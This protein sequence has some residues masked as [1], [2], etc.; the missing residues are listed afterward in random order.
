M[1]QVTAVDFLANALDINTKSLIFEQAKEME[2]KLIMQSYSD[3][4]G[5]GVAVGNGDCSFKSVSDEEQYYNETFN[6]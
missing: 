4:L 5:N 2:K 1:K 6:K 3:G